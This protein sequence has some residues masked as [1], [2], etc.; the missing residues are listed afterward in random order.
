MAINI[1]RDSSAKVAILVTS[2]IAINKL[3]ELFNLTAPAVI[4]G[5][6]V[7]LVV[8]LL[9][10]STA[11]QE[12]DSTANERRSDNSD[13]VKFCLASLLI[14]SI[15]AAAAMLPIFDDRKLSAP[16]D[17]GIP[18][19]YYH[20]YEAGA[21][22]FITLLAAVA[23]IR[24]R[25]PLQIFAFLASATAGMTFAIAVRPVNELHEEFQ[26]ANTFITWLALAALVTF[27]VYETPAL[28]R[29]FSDF[30]FKPATESQSELA[31]HDEQ[32]P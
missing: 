1:S 31:A 28:I 23:A 7:V 29:I 8:M 3:S 25:S 4:L 20:L 17:V 12:G 15:I 6:A 18:G 27:F 11:S 21:A 26:F 2:G 22:C 16:I 19:A 9:N 5:S 30:W 32:R 13:F 24:R 10:D 14:G